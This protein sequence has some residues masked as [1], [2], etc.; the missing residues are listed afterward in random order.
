M[1]FIKK[2]QVF[3]DPFKH[4]VC[5]I[6]TSC[7]PLDIQRYLESTPSDDFI[8]NKNANFQKKELRKASDQLGKILYCMCS[9]ELLQLCE[10][11][12]GLTRLKPD[13]TFDGGGITVTG[14]PGFLRYHVDFPYSSS[15]NAYR[16]VNTILYLNNSDLRGGDLHLL[17][18]ISKT[19]EKVIKPKFGLLVAFMTS[20]NTPHGFSKIKTG[21]R[22]SVNSYF[23]HAAP[24]DDRFEPTKTG[25]IDVIN[26]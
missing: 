3:S 12:F 14:A 10:A 15:A 1:I 24:L 21:T 26:N 13:E 9:S 20:K 4:I 11:E 17:D 5:E 7:S 23:Y 19:V 16:V 2:K 8:V 22:I 18:P 25:W 6:D